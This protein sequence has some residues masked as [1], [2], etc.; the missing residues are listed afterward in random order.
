M[1]NIRFIGL[2]DFNINERAIINEI[3]PK[4]SKKI[5]RSMEDY[6]LILKFK[7]HSTA[8][9][10]ID[11]SVK[12][13]MHAK[14]ESP[15]MIISSSYADWDLRRTLHKTLEKLQ[16]EVDHKVQRNRKPWLRFFR[17]NV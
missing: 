2:E 7:K 8:N 15:K 4:H 5:S 17:R 10:R 13:S 9:K 6:V 11:E 3:V 1:E 12:F 16:K 14:I